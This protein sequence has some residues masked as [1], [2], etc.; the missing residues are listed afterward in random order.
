MPAVCLYFKVHQPFQLNKFSA[1]DIGLSHRYES[2]EAD[3]AIIHMLANCCYLPANN[4]IQ[5]LIH[6]HKGLF[7]VSYS[8]SGPTLTLLQRYRPD[9]IL[10]FRNLLK[11]GCVELLAE[12]WNHSLSFLH[13]R[14]EFQRQVV[15]HSNAIKSLFAIKPEVFRNTELIYNNELAT[16]VANLGFKGVLCEG[17][18]RILNKRNINQVY[19][20]AGCNTLG[21][22]LRHPELSDDIAFRFGDATWSGHPLTAEKFAAWLHAHPN[23]TDVINIFMDY[24]TFGFHRKRE[25][26]IFHFLQNLP[27]NVFAD[28][29]FTFSTPSDVLQTNEPKD[30]YDVQQ[31]ISWEDKLHLGNAW[32]ENV[33]QH[34]ILKKIYSIE[35][36]VIKSGCDATIDTWGKLQAADYFHYMAEADEKRQST[37]FLQPEEMYQSYT[38]IITDFEISLIRKAIEKNKKRAPFRSLVTGLL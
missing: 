15:K 38:N 1:L 20:A 18:E 26:G 35:N 37:W 13:S 21:L 6:E 14:T 9:V 4:I 32:W 22:L 25:T 8:I 7:K 10:S 12:T 28:N 23:D 31:T 19:T 27:A 24:E 30:V 16:C 3:E 11:T 34:N 5:R 29:A 17:V 2:P 33:R 36:L